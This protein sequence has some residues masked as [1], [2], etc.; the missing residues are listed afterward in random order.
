[1]P[2]YTAIRKSL[3]SCPYNIHSSVL[4]TTNI[5]YSY[6][7]QSYV[8]ILTLK[9]SHT[10]LYRNEEHKRLCISQLTILTKNNSG[11]LYMYHR[12]I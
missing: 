11:R 4:P 5:L 12:V 3:A 2:C 7:A 9:H 10:S 8:Y 1:M 6:V